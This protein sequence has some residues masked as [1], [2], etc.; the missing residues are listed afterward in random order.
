ME[1]AVYLPPI[2]GLNLQNS[3]QLIHHRPD[4]ENIQSSKYL[5]LLGVEIYLTSFYW[6][7]SGAQH[8]PII[9]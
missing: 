4:F 2:L 5:L 6:P 3:L 1:P 8:P 9:A 7:L